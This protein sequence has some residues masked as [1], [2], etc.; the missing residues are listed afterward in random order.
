MSQQ[1][2]QQLSLWFS[3][4]KKEHVNQTTSNNCS[5][6]HPERVR[7]VKYCYHN[8]L[9]VIFSPK[10]ITWYQNIL[11]TQQKAK[12]N[13]TSL[14]EDLAGW[15]WPTSLLSDTPDVDRKIE[16]PLHSSVTQGTLFSQ[17]LLELYP[18]N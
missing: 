12:M 16:V 9:K 8:F 4:L 10:Q 15:F 5:Q 17:D 11:Q 1:R 2:P 14:L 13:D 7:P 6:F 18:A 3:E